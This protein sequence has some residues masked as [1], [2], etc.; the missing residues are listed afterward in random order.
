MT[1]TV[2]FLGTCLILLILGCASGISR[3]VRSQVTYSGTFAQLQ[4]A[5]AEHVG[6][7]V[8]LCAW[9]RD[10]GFATSARQEGSAPGWRPIRGPLP[11]SIRTISRSCHLSERE[12]ADC[13]GKA[14][15]QRGSSYRRFSV[16]LSSG[17]SN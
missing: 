2:R 16:C 10:Y 17:G 6:E 15:R 7:I 4:T 14:Q 12:Q 3:Q 11:C 5:P 13:G 8:M 9:L 1:R